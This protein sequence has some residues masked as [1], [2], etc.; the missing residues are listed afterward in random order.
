MFFSGPEKFNHR[1][2]KNVVQQCRSEV[3]HF[4]TT[5]VQAEKDITHPVPTHPNKSLLTSASKNFIEEVMYVQPGKETRVPLISS[6]QDCSNLQT[7]HLPAMCNVLERTNISTGAPPKNLEFSTV[8]CFDGSPGGTSVPC[9][10]TQTPCTTANQKLCKNP[11]P[12]GVFWDFENCP[13]PKG[14]SAL[15]IVRKLRSV[16]F[17]ERREVEFMC[18][19]D[20]SKEKKAVIEELNKAQVQTYLSLPTFS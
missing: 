6:A 11:E 10:R 14:K 7:N 19:C 13:V 18:V 2:Y 3:Q 9:R 8:S 1:C 16:F 20:I 4:T 5:R 15:A 17:K 12:V